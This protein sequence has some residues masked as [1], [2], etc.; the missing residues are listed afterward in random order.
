MDYTIIGIEGMEFFAH[1]GY[2]PSEQVC[3]NR[4]GVDVYLQLRVD[5]ALLEDELSGTV[6]YE[7]V[8]EVCRQLMAEPVKLLET[9]AFT[10]ADTLQQKYPNVETITV[11]VSKWGVPGAVKIARTF[12]EVKKTW[13]K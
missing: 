7:E 4:F 6:N 9:L 13:D 10:I 1:H 8:F 11:R 12:V 2:Y 3:G 5:A